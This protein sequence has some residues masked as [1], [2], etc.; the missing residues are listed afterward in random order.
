[1]GDGHWRF[2]EMAHGDGDAFS[3]DFSAAPADEALLAR[4]CRFLQTD[5]ASPFIQNLVV[6]RRTADT[7]LS[8]RGRVLA[9]IHATRVD[10]KLL[11][12]AEELVATL[13]D[14]FEL[15]TPEAAALWPSICARH[16]ALFAGTSEQVT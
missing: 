13:R 11:N 16:E 7:H 2:A 4:K 15:D 8:L 3:F 5:P 10:K 1:L 14:S 12:S 6:Q 9:T